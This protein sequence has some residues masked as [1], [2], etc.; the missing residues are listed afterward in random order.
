LLFLQAAAG[1]RQQPAEREGDRAER[2][3]PGGTHRLLLLDDSNDK[4][5]RRIQVPFLV[6]D[7]VAILST[8]RDTER[9]RER[10]TER[11]KYNDRWS[12]RW[13]R[14]SVVVA[15]RHISFCDTYITK[16]EERQRQTKKIR[17][18]LL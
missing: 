15:L 10:D 12:S 16:Q 6:I 13:N 3:V 17:T 11:D 14:I 2:A 8:E 4:K 9:E 5:N 1:A 7:V 18:R